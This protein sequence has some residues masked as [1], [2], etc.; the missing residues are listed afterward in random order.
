MSTPRRAAL[1][2]ALD[3]LGELDPTPSVAVLPITAE[4]WHQSLA[5][6]AIEAR[7][8]AYEACRSALLE[9]EREGAAIGRDLRPRALRFADATKDLADALELL[10][11][12]DVGQVD[13]ARTAAARRE[14]IREDAV[15]VICG[16]VEDLDVPELESQFV[17]PEFADV[18]RD[19][20]GDAFGVPAADILD[21]A[22]RFRTCFTT[23][24]GSAGR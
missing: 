22:G 12:L 9:G 17:F 5:D 23:L 18:E 2:P 15:Q 16:V 1:R 14:S 19:V 24:V 8:S 4:Q 6:A 20:I 10:A 13:T 7:S 21:G 11:T 3:L